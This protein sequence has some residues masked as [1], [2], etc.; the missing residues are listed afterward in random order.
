[1][2]HS[3]CVR[4][5]RERA[6][7]VGLSPNFVIYDEEDR[8]SLVKEAMRELDMDERQTTPASVVHRISHAKNHM[9]TVEKAERLAPPPRGARLAQLYPL[10]EE[11]LPAAGAGDF[12]DLRRPPAKPRR[13]SAAA[14]AR[15][16]VV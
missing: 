10:S 8:L 14:L 5:L 15:C 6:R 7:L 12:H 16:R 9:L 4:I 11:K 1:T 13:R 2:F 3:T